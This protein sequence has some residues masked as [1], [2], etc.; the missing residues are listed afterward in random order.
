PFR[1]TSSAVIFH[2]ILGKTP[3]PPVRLNPDV[4]PDLDRL[5]MKALE[6]DRD[7]RCQS[8]AEVRSDLKRLKRDRESGSL[9]SPSVAASVTMPSPDVASQPLLSSSQLTSAPPSSSSDVQVA[10]ALL[11][12]HRT[13]VAIGVI[14]LVLAVVG[15]LYVIGP[16]RSPSA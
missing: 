5:I 12:R 7:V 16:R 3:V 8:A 11:K 4:P 13:A 14:A 6:K 1:G 2:E 15:I 10:A 9:S